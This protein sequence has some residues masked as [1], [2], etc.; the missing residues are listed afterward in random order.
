MQ[1]ILYL[2]L[3]LFFLLVTYIFIVLCDRLME[4]KG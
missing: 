2:G 4:K 1:D 3:S